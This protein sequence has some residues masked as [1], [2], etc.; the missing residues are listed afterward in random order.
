MRK[1]DDVRKY[2]VKREIKKKDKTFFKSPKIQRLIT[3]KR[4]RRK[5]LDKRAKVDG[6][7]A[8]KDARAKYEKL[9]SNYIKEK[10][11]LSVKKEAPV[12]EK[13]PV[14][15]PTKVVQKGGKKDEKKPAPVK[16]VV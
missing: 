1:K 4:I 3:E 7:K 11:A 10:K 15:A 16:P 6:F 8:R 14:A 13:A 5:K 12:E 2:V 9:L